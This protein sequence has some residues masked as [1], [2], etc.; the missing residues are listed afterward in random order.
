MPSTSHLYQLWYL[1][2]ARHQSS[3]LLRIIFLSVIIFSMG[4]AVCL[5][6]AY[7]KAK[8]KFSSVPQ[9]CRWSFSQLKYVVSLL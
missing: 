2:D 6:R 3:L 7:K 1:W 9:K 4:S 5:T 8:L